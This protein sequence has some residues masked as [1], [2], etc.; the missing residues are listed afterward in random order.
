[1]G[2]PIR[3]SG[4]ADAMEALPTRCSDLLSLG[5]EELAKLAAAANGT[6]GAQRVFGKIGGWLRATSD[7]DEF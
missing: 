3:V 1:M 4:L 7:R 6:G 5:V 2:R